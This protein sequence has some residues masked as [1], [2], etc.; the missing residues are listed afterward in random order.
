MRVYN[1]N[2]NSKDVINTINSIDYIKIIYRVIN[3]G[4]NVLINIIINLISSELL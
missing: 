4:V 2:N 1:I 3:I